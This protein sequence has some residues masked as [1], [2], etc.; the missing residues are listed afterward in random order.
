MVLKYT[1][2]VEEDAAWLAICACNICSTCKPS[3]VGRTG[4]RVDRLLGEWGMAQDSVA[5]R[6]EFEAQMETRRAGERDGEFKAVR[7]G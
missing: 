4:W 7:P 1:G 6:R 2:W 3:R 5:G